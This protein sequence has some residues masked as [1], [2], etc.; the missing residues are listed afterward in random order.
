M[1]DPIASLSVAE[2]LAVALGYGIA[3]GT[4]LSAIPVSLWLVY[5]WVDNRLHSPSRSERAP[6]PPC[7]QNGNDA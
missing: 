6:T 7:S 5:D 4:L 1:S 3:W 2:L